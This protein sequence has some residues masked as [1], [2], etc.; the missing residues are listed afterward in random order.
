[1]VTS[2]ALL[3]SLEGFW[4]SANQYRLPVSLPPV[5]HRLLVDHRAL[6]F[7][8]VPFGSARFF[9]VATDR[10]RLTLQTDVEVA[11]SMRGGVPIRT[12]LL[13]ENPTSPR[14]LVETAGAFDI[15]LRRSMLLSQR[16][17]HVGICRA[18]GVSRWA[19]ES[20]LT[21]TLAFA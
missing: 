7:C 15:D 19:T 6:G 16:G 2:P 18:A 17:Y 13:M 20:D 11:F 10:E 14:E 3:V 5:L 8:I 12:V 9:G 1:M 4:P 21:R